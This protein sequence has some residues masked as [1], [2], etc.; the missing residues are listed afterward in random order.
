MHICS[1]EINAVMALI[2]MLPEIRRWLRNVLSRISILE[3]KV[4]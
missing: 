4:V 1:E 3:R 2:P